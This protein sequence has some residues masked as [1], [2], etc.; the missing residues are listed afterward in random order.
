MSG[1]R[2]ILG[3]ERF[4]G[5]C[6]VGREWEECKIRIGEKESIKCFS[7]VFF[8]LIKLKEEKE[9]KYVRFW[10]TSSKTSTKRL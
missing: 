7:C 3:K 5:R 6:E 10:R 9:R 1:I 8:G 4:L 2:I